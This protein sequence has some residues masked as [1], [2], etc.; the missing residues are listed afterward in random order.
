MQKLFI[1]FIFLKKVK[2]AF[3]FPIF[4]VFQAMKNEQIIFPTLFFQKTA[5]LCFCSFLLS[6]QMQKYFSISTLFSQRH[7]KAN[8]LFALFSPQK[9]KRHFC[10]SFFSRNETYKN[11]FCSSISFSAKLWKR[12]VFLAFVFWNRNCFFAC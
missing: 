11:K 4:F 6:Q 10:C 3:F 2:N 1:H 5:K 8:T 12:H 9:Y 7:K